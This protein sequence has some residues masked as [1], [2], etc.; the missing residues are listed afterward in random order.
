MKI[1]IT[2][3]G[4]DSGKSFFSAIITEALKADYWKPIQ[5]G[6]PRDT[7]Y[8]K[9]LISNKISNFLPEA[10]VLNTPA[11]P[12]WAAE[13]DGIKLKLND[14]VLPRTENKHLVIEGAGGAL[15]PINN[16][17]F[18]ID[19]PQKWQIP[20]ILVANLYLG[21]I[22]HTLLTLN[23]LKRRGVQLLGI[24]FNGSSQ[25]SSEEIILK[26][27]DV[28]C[29]LKIDQ[30]KEINQEIIRKYAEELLKNL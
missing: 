3:I 5:A 9:Q 29:L 22:N 30:E 18:V 14:F 4:T 21:S 17:E 28:P 2:A 24:V 25:P 13:I 19:L 8:V 6:F 23:E 12:H 1:F 16:E 20:V 10:Y 26:H 7:E 15:V 11:S 27:A